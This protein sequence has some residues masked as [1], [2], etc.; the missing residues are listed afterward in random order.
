MN[1]REAKVYFKLG[2][3][4]IFHAAPNIPS[5]DIYV[6]DKLIAENLGFGATTAY[7]PMLRENYRISIYETGTNNLLLTR[8]VAIAA[9]EIITLAIAES[10]PDGENDVSFLIIPDAHVVID[11]EKSMLCFI[12]LSP[13]APAVDVTL[14]DGTV[15]FGNV[16]YGEITPYYSL[17][18]GVYN[19]QIRAAGTS[20]VLL[21]VP[22]LILDADTYYSIYLIGLVGGEPPLQTVFMM[23]SFK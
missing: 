4:R 15:L 20:D 22:S 1:V 2:Y 5:V 6:D 14:T 19:L 16:A 17:D 7:L 18:P 13:D 12:N 21:E 11:P 9:D 3:F 10:T 23:D 8:F